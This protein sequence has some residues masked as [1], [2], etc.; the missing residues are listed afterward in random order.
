VREHVSAHA[1]NRHPHPHRHPHRPPQIGLTRNNPPETRNA[2][3]L[4][5]L[6]LCQVYMAVAA[7]WLRGALILSLIG[8]NGADDRGYHR[9]MVA[10]RRVTIRDVAQAAGVSTT[11]VSD[12]LSGNGR[13]PAT[14]RSRVAAVA[15]RLGYQA[16]PAAR[17]LRRR[18]VGGIGLYLPDE[19][20]NFPYY[21]ELAVGAASQALAH[22]MALT[23]IPHSPDPT[24][25]T[26]FPVD[27]LAAVHPVTGDP[28]VRAFAQLGIPV[29]TCEK[30]L[31]PGAKHAG[32]VEG[33]YRSAMT[34]LLDHLRKQ[35]A[36]R[37][38]LIA[39]SPRT[40]W[41][42]ELRTA[43]RA[44][45]SAA[46]RPELLFDVPCPGSP[47]LVHDAAMA[48]LRA[49]PPA[50]APAD[51]PGDPSANAPADLRANPPADAIVSGIDG[52]AIGALLAAAE[53]GR[54]VPEDLLVASCVDSPGLR[55][56]SPAITAL[57]LR[58][59]EMGRRLA[60]LLH[61]LLENTV[62]PGTVQVVHP[63]LLIRPST[64][65]YR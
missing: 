42:L 31:T 60:S 15:G 56:C 35:G 27:G 49:N 47:E 63:R 16:N 37:I 28:V 29:V 54:R 57:D 65:R 7:T 23:L 61:S 18:R 43:Y 36:E 59:D 2:N 6:A 40:A 41:G 24:R 22:G 4:K 14:T 46:G 55:A 45:C 52:G 11:T 10:T 1:R 38:A 26:A 50:N 48:A 3:S 25:L 51:P 12:A 8:I 64:T 44:W 17:S 13:L 5:F 30:D 33:D 32:R 62:P 9:R 21:L 39:S 20:G 53:L 34:L 19:A 58:P